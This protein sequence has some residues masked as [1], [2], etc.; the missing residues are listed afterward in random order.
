[1]ELGVT[2]QRAV[3]LLSLLH[4]VSAKQNLGSEAQEIRRFTE[5]LIKND[6]SA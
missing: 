6:T 5:V 3:L 1:M 2:T 4:F